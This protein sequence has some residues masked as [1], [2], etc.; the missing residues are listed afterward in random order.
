MLVLAL[1]DVVW[2]VVLCRG[3]TLDGSPPPVLRGANVLQGGEGPRQVIHT[4][5]QTHLQNEPCQPE[6]GP[7]VDVWRQRPHQ[8]TGEVPLRL[9][10]VC[11]PAGHRHFQHTHHSHQVAH[12]P[13]AQGARAPDELQPPAVLLVPLCNVRHRPQRRLPQCKALVAQRVRRRPIQRSRKQLSD[14]RRERDSRHGAAALHGVC[15]QVHQSRGNRRVVE[16]PTRLAA[17]APTAALP[18]HIGGGDGR[19]RVVLLMLLVDGLYHPVCDPLDGGPAG[20]IG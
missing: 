20:R 5:T 8:T 18:I 2:F 7:L 10:H 15:Q 16:A 13:G 14:H 6:C 4:P 9:R 3:R 1:V 19:T 11:S 17:E 12:A